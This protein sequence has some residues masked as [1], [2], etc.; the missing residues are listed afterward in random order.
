MLQLL[1]EYRFS[2]ADFIRMKLASS[3]G[4]C[5]RPVLMAA[6]GVRTM[7][8]DLGA[9][10]TVAGALLG[11]FQTAG[12]LQALGIPQALS[13]ASG[14]KRDSGNFSGVGSPGSQRCVGGEEGYSQCCCLLHFGGDLGT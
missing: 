1:A 14:E 11:C 3:R 4:I 12:S 10:E 5:L 7:Q 8:S 9:Q 13:S 6:L 2:V